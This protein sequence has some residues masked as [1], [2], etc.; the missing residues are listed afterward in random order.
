MGDERRSVLKLTPGLNH[1]ALSW[2]MYNREEDGPIL[3]L[4]GMKWRVFIRQR[5]ANRFR[6]AGRFNQI[7]TN[8]FLA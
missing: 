4:G 7:W 5:K 1:P 8:E 3:F 2:Y 6:L